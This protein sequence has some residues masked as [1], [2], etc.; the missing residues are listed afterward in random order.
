MGASSCSFFDDGN[1]DEFQTFLITDWMTHTPKEVLAKNFI[2]PE[3]TFD[4]VPKKELF[5]FQTGLPGD[6]KEGAKRGRRSNRHRAEALRFQGQ[7][8][9][10]NQGHGRRRR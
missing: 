2:L 7:R 9:E 4:K 1:F 6:L 8:N 5:I 3:S 10:T